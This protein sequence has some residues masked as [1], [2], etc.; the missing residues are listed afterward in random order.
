MAGTVHKQ[1]LYS[2]PGRSIEMVNL[3]EK[4]G[5]QELFEPRVF[6]SNR[7]K[8]NILFERYGIVFQSVCK[9]V[10][11]SIYA[12]PLSVQM[13]KGLNIVVGETLWNLLFK[14]PSASTFAEEL[15]LELLHFHKNDEAFFRLSTNDWIMR[16]NEYY[17]K[18]DIVFAVHSV[19]PV[20]ESIK[21]KGGEDDLDAYIFSNKVMSAG[22]ALSGEHL[23]KMKK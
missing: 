17:L 12:F 21:Y 4:I 9:K 2:L 1:Y 8:E 19:Y 23:I 15:F 3:L 13:P 5:L 6:F 11:R 10:G 22:A 14:T 20:L 16:S 18:D 7:L